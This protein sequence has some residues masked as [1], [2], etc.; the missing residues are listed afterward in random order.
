MKT[1]F[2][3]SALFG[4]AMVSTFAASTAAHAV[5]ALNV[6]ISEIRLYTNAD[7]AGSRTAVVYA[8]GSNIGEDSTKTVNL[9]N[10]TQR[11]GTSFSIETPAAGTYEAIGITFD[12]IDVVSG[13]TTLDL[14]AQMITAGQLNASGVM[15][16]GENGT[17]SRAVSAPAAPG[18]NVSVTGVSS[19]LVSGGG[20]ISL[21]TLNFVLDE[22][23]IVDNS[24]TSFSVRSLP[25]I[26]PTGTL[27]GD[28]S[29][30][31][32]VSVTVDTTAFN[33]V[34]GWTA[35]TTK[36]RVG[37]F[38]TD[39]PERPLA[40]KQFTSPS[41]NG[42]VQREFVDAPVGNVAAIA[43]IDTDGDGR[44]DSGEYM[45]ASNTYVADM[46]EAV[47]GSADISFTGV[48]DAT[49]FRMG[50]RAISLS[51]IGSDF[52]E[53]AALLL[54]G[55]FDNSLWAAGIGTSMTI[56]NATGNTV[57][58]TTAEPI[59][60]TISFQYALNSD[61]SLTRTVSLSVVLGANSVSDTSNV[62]DGATWDVDFPA[63]NALIS[64]GYIGF[65]QPV[66]DTSVLG[67]ISW[68]ASNTAT[69]VSPTLTITDIPLFITHLADNST[70]GTYYVSVTLDL[71]DTGTTTSNWAASTTM[72]TSTDFAGS[73]SSF[74]GV[75]VEDPSSNGITLHG[76]S[77]DDDGATDTDGEDALMFNQ[78]DS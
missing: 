31:A 73:Q 52:S 68:T 77:D 27:G 41:T 67:G 9:F 1:S 35:G 7:D 34:A 44:L 60:G 56:S 49:A 15:L 36:V 33:A 47:S 2:V 4:A 48:L 5:D 59:T 51:I 78:G 70:S 18:L 38:S 37:L 57:T 65:Q 69:S 50:P 22:S 76:E 26:I 62:I 46:Y 61:R 19:P 40:S 43:W 16:L 13:T 30:R 32:N 63:G 55:G 24:A 29:A 54:N 12:S 17:G 25:T 28:S 21:P 66:T 14:R 75:L 8:P 39:L 74:T 53:Y 23:D 10:A 20:A 11:A 64:N 45:T 72:L 3:K 42:T 6:V 71:T 58:S